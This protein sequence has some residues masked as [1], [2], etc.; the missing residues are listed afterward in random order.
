M[1]PNWFV[2][3]HV[4]TDGWFAPLV[5]DAPDH[6]R[7]FHPD[8]VHLTVA[9]LGG[10]GE[11]AAMAAWARADLSDGMPAFDAT[12]DTMRPM[13]YPRR[14]SALSLT[15]SD[16]HDEAVAIMRG[17]RDPMVAAAGR[18]PET[19][20]PLPHITV[21]RPARNCSPAERKAA[22]VWAKDK[23][24]L[25]AAVRIETLSLYTWSDD[26][27]QQQFRAVVSRQL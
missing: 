4:P 16:G 19:R 14:P 12:L 27:R 5:A 8:D 11:D 10:C 26:R 18:P 22:V 20:E 21:A 15:L 7:V 3:L 9:F 2:G 17:L 1:R 23:P 25:Q 13:G 24:S 6:L